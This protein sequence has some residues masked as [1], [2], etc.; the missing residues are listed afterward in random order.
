MNP[1]VSDAVADTVTFWLTENKVPPAGAVRLTTGAAFPGNG[2]AMLIGRSAEFTMI[3]PSLLVAR[4][5]SV[6]VPTVNPFAA[7][8]L[9][10]M[11]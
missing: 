1:S 3:P 8:S 5:V 10:A 6:C 2:A 4:A 9:K 11:L 7:D